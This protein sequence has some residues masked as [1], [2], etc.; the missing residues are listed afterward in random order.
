MSL[1]S[2]TLLCRRYRQRRDCTGDGARPRSDRHHIGIA[3]NQP[4]RTSHCGYCSAQKH[5][6]SGASAHQVPSKS[7]VTNTRAS[8]C[9]A[10]TLVRQVCSSPRMNTF[11]AG[12]ESIEER[13]LA[14]LASSSLK[15]IGYGGVCKL[16]VPAECRSQGAARRAAELLRKTLPRLGN[17]LAADAVLIFN[18]FRPL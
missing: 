12:T 11:R 14:F 8:R 1:G 13:E 6:G 2:R 3:P 7:E 18:R 16:F 15:G 17:V 5:V 4:F 9:R 10:L